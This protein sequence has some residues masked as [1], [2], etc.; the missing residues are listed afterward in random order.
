MV[1]HVNVSIRNSA[2][3]AVKIT[4]IESLKNKLNLN[5]METIKRMFKYIWRNIYG[6]YTVL[7][8]ISILGCIVTNTEINNTVLAVGIITIAGYAN[9]CYIGNKEEIK[10]LKKEIEKIK[11]GHS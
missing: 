4:E 9:E 2:L 11:K 3:N 10:E 8:I 5:N 6:I 1:L 7:F